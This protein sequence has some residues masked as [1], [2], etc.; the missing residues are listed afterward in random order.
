[1]QC[2][3]QIYYVVSNYNITLVYFLL[4]MYPEYNDNAIL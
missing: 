1:M 4:E 2:L 3:E